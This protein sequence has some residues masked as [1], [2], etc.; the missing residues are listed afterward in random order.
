MM[1]LTSV[2]YVKTGPVLGELGEDVLAPFSH[3]DIIKRGSYLYFPEEAAEY[4]YL[5][6]AGRIRLMR[7]EGNEETTVAFLTG[8]DVF[9]ELSKE[10]HLATDALEVIE[11]VV[12]RTLERRPFDQLI[13]T[14]PIRELKAV[15]MGETDRL[16]VTIPLAEV[17]ETTP[18]E[19]VSRLI[20]K[21]TDDVGV[22]RLDGNIE[23]PF[24]LTAESLIHLTGL[25]EA[26]VSDVLSRLISDHL[27]E[28]AGRRIIV[29]NRKELTKVAARSGTPS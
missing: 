10:G 27:I 20:L 4:V 19:R 9:G 5:V 26:S 3:V 1:R 15:L 18:L 23:I 8:G 7:L 29:R 11:D 24:K 17:I 12:I 28:I 2:W 13:M 14:P 22:P 6:R 21:L 16:T 25:S